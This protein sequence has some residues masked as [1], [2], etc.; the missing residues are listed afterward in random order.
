MIGKTFGRW[1]ILEYVKRDKNG[2]LIFK[3]QC[4]CENK[5]IK[6][7]L[8][9]SLKTG[10]TKSCGCL[11]PTENTNIE[12]IMQKELEKRNYNFKTQFKILIYSVDILLTDYNII[13]EC[14]GRYWHDNPMSKKEINNV[15]LK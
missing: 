11:H 13:I 2:N 15:I 7:C 6:N 10:H 3:C 8:L 14:D 12:L 5:T 4:Q 1:K 9:N